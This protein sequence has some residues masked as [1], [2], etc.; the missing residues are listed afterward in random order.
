VPALTPLRTG[1]PHPLRANWRT[2]SHRSAIGVNPA[3]LQR[4]SRFNVLIR[5]EIPFVL[6]QVLSGGKLVPN[7]VGSVPLSS[8]PFHVFHFGVFEADLRSGELRRNGVKVKLHDQPFQVLA[9]L[10]ERPGELVTREEIG[11]RLWPAD[12]FVDFDHGLNN[13]VNRLR[14]ALGDSANKPGFIETLPRRGYRFIMPVQSGI[15]ARMEAIQWP[16]L[17]IPPREPGD[18]I[19]AAAP[20]G[21]PAPV[22]LP[23]GRRDRRVGVAVA[24]VIAVLLSVGVV[25]LRK[26]PWRSADAPIQ[27]LVVLPLENVSGDPSQEYFADGMTDSLITELA[28]LGDKRV[29]SRTSAMHYTRSARTVARDRTRAGGRCCGGRNRDPGG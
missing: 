8:T 2:L 27:S 22:P 21:L 24:L 7:R 10:L 16:P 9:M 13:A 28:G 5:E 4:F 3:A 14:E 6:K 1:L 23:A 11:Q 15:R 12:T 29:I 26:A 18:G 25:V 17:D 20:T 19:E